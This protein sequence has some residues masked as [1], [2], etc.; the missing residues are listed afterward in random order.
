MTLT[1][2]KPFTR[3]MAAS[4]LLSSC[5]SVLVTEAML[6]VLMAD[7]AGYQVFNYVGRDVLGQLGSLCVMMGLTKHIDKHPKR[8]LLFSHTLQQC[9][10]ASV[11]L[12]PSLPSH[13]FLPVAAFSNVCLNVSF[14]G[15][16]SISAKCINHFAREQNN[17][18]ELYSKLTVHGT[19][20]SSLGLSLGMLLSK[21]ALVSPEAAC[22]ALG[23]ARILSY[24]KAVSKLL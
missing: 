1:L 17:V 22:V 6:H 16:G 4:T 21:S 24:Q 18:G 10:V 8:F 2:W 15:F 19:L 5:Q 12:T 23:V 9:A 20:A 3:W 14:M 7:T 11:L 13:W